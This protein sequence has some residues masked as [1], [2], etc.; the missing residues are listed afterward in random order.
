MNM[1]N[2]F[3]FFCTLFVSQDTYSYILGSENQLN[4]VALQS[5]G[6]IVAT[7][8]TVINNTQYLL[9]AR[10]TTNGALDGTFGENGTVTVLAGE[11][12]IGY[13][14][15]VDSGGLITVVG[16]TIVGGISCITL[17]RLTTNG[18]LDPSFGV[19]GIVLSLFEGG[20]GGHALWI[21][22]NEK[23]LVSGTVVKNS[24]VYIPIIR[25]NN[26]GSVD[27]SFADNGISI[28][29]EED[30]VIAYAM[31]MQS[32]GKILLAGFAESQ[33][34]VVRCMAD[35]QI[36]TSFGSGGISSLQV[37][38]SS[39]I[40]GIDLQSN[41][42]IVVGGFSNGQCMVARFQ[43]NGTLDEGFADHGIALNNFSVYNVGLDLGI[44][45]ND[46]VLLVGLSDASAIL[47]RY[48]ANGLLDTSFGNQ[49]VTRVDCGV[50]NVNAIAV[51]SDEKII[52]AGFS[53]S[54]AMLARVDTNGIFDKE[55]GVDGV[56][57][58]P[59]NYFPGCGTSENVKG[60][61]F[62]YDTTTQ[63]VSIANTF[64]DITL[65]T[66]AQLVGWSH[67]LGKPT[68]TCIRSG[69]Y[70]VTYNI[71]SERTSGSGTISASLRCTLNGIEIPGSQVSYDFTTNSQTLSPT[72]T[73]IAAFNAGDNLKFQYSAGSTACR[74]IAG[75]G[76]GTTRCSITVSIIQIA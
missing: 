28:I 43:T 57:L 19:N 26:D 11:S 60:Y 54:N 72:R 14:I 48:T 20:C 31:T 24:E 51:Q 5:D 30:C 66:N 63:T 27:T 71:V 39:T 47:C 8:F 3:L 7:G 55:F 42:K 32:D 58:D 49:G 44:D 46:R 67:L 29:D 62:A 25:Y 45:K 33:G 59:T 21:D 52:I 1:L 4:S 76:N 75:D 41:G 65:N 73:F 35:G 69:M 2:R 13:G 61:V 34:I 70:Q 74:I 38:L 40:R 12:P 10:Y 36:D 22:E 56:L 17:V 68:F 23:I 50:G 37:G 53:D 16:S 64:Q 6:K 15:K 9:I 18:A